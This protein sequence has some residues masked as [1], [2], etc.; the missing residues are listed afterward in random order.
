MNFWQ[1][2]V[3]QGLI[4]GD[5]NY[6]ASGQATQGEYE[7]AFSVAIAA[8][9]SKG[10]TDQLW[11]NMVSSGAIQ[12]DPTYY[13]TGK[14]A[15]DEVTNALN[16]ATNFYVSGA[17]ASSAAGGPATTD[18]DPATLPGVLAGGYTIRNK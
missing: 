5:P 4:A 9:Q 14:A 10:L 17:G 13:S 11:A 1:W 12:G 8:A 7:H 16:V 2:A 3:D 18:A 6:Y 15:P